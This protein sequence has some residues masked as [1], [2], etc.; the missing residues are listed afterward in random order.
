MSEMRS[1]LQARKRR[2]LLMLL[3]TFLVAWCL[4]LVM[5]TVHPPNPKITL[6][7]GYMAFQG[8]ES[9]TYVVNVTVENN[10]A[11]GQVTVH[12][13][14]SSPGMYGMETQR[15]YLTSNESK[16]LQF[17]FHIYKTPHTHP[18]ICKISRHRAWAEAR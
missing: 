16:S 9:C 3:Y 11:E 2:I 7:T 13:E 6:V 17:E 10:G 4:T 15:I 18:D 14:I 1:W 12:C 5:N 8:V